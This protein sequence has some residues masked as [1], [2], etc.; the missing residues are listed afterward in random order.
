MMPEEEKKK[1]TYPW[2]HKEDKNVITLELFSMEPN[3]LKE[4][5]DKHGMFSIMGYHLGAFWINFGKFLQ[6]YSGKVNEVHV[7]YPEKN[8]VVFIAWLIKLN[9]GQDTKIYW[10]EIQ[11]SKDKFLVGHLD[12]IINIDKFLEKCNSYTIRE[13]RELTEILAGGHLVI[14]DALYQIDFG[15]DLEQKS[16]YL[17]KEEVKIKVL[18]K[19]A[20]KK[21]N[22]VTS[23]QSYGRWELRDFRERVVRDHVKK[24]DECLLVPCTITKPYYGNLNNVNEINQELQAKTKRAIRDS[25]DNKD[26]IVMTTIGIAPQEFWQDP[27]DLGYDVRVPDLWADYITAKNFFTKFQYN[28]VYCWLNYNPYIEIVKILRAYGIIKEIEF[29]YNQENQPIKK[30][31]FGAFFSIPQGK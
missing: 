16:Q 1:F 11:Q 23:W 7:K 15:T 3:G 19:D 20:I 17:D 25:K 12:D 10:Y 26:I 6:R 30:G 18:T 13:L 24:H 14:A 9:L 28:K 31:N 27:I 29:C 21:V 8:I 22:K 5:A 4:W 2:K